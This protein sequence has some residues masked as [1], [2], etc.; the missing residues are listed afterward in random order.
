M[1]RLRHATRT[2]FRSLHTRNFRLFFGGQLISQAGTWM[3]TV[4][5]V[6]VVLDLTDSGVALG[7][8]TAAQF[9]PML[10]LG[11]WAGVLADRV[12]RHH[13]MVATQV[14]F[15]VV[16]VALSALT[17]T[18]RATVGAM[19]LLS[20]VF[21]VITAIDN[22]ARR[23]LVSE[24]VDV[25]DVPNAVGLNSALMTGSRVLGPALAG[26]LISGPGAAWCFVLN[27]VTYLAVIAALLRMDRSRFRSSPP[28]ARAKGQLREGLLY[29]WRTPILRLSLV[30]VG[31]VGIAAFNYPVTLPLLAERTFSGDATT[32]TLLYATMSL[33]SVAGALTVARRTEIDARYLVG[34]GI[35]LAVSTTVLAFAP[36]LPVAVLAALP[37]GY[38]SIYLIAGCNTVVQLHA[39]PSMRGRV[40]ALTA[41]LFLGTTPIGGPIVGWIS[42]VANPRVGVF[43]GAVGTALATLWVVRQLRSGSADDRAPTHDAESLAA[44]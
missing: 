13:L 29:A 41:V 25:E 15:T 40:L 44:A 26:L 32:F 23:V 42:E 9:L 5:I 24:L 21:G 27:A 39:D 6:W 1:S 33:G 22:P 2:T 20:A 34:S 10:L 17:L 3:Q 18:D 16:A 36:V 28:V 8:V 37:V 30:L 7:L 4:A 19:Y 11:A 43:V 12:D 35:G 31:A 14:A 38:S